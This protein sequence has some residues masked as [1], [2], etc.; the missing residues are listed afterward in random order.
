MTE[1]TVQ[2]AM[3]ALDDLASDGGLLN[4]EQANTFIRML[5][6]QPTMLNAVRSVPMNSP[7]MELNKIG[8][9]TRILRAARQSTAGNG[10]AL[11]ESERAK[12]TTSK[13]ELS[14][15]EVIAEIRLPYEVLED[16]IE[17]GNMENTVLALIAERAALDLEELILLGDTASGD[18]YLALLNGIL[19][20]STD[21]VVDAMG[22]PISADVFNTA[23]KALPTQYRR[24]RAAMNFFVPMDVEQDYRLALSSRGT[25]L[26]DDLLTGNR[27]VP[28]FG[29][30]MKG[31]ALMPGSNLL[32]TDPQNIIMGVQRAIR[33]ES[34]RLISEREIK[35]V[36]TARIAL[37]I[38]ETEAMTKVINLG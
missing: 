38:E 16:N 24:N 21:N 26:G 28:V 15:K 11:I 32:F 27:A 20:L 13:V 36:L 19:K 18:S 33:I 2:R 8:F 17:R 10:R 12:P 30:P 29:V 1:Q 6:D 25:S 23:L 14:T 22:E 7:S 4:V 31:A 9:G 5:I 37:A 35:I 34:E 3:I